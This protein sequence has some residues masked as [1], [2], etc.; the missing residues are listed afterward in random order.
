[1]MSL[2]A[3]GGLGGKGYVFRAVAEMFV[4]LILLLPLSVDALMAVGTY[5]GVSYGEWKMAILNLSAIAYFN[6]GIMWLHAWAVA[7]L[8]GGHVVQ[9]RLFRPVCDALRLGR[10]GSLDLDHRPERGPIYSPFNRDHGHRVRSQSCEEE[11]A[12]AA[13]R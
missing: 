10:L 9:F 12:Q 5:A 1:M 3:A 11:G 2:A 7:V 8:H 6:N 13:G 4:Y